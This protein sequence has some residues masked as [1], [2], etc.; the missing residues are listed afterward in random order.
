MKRATI[1]VLAVIG[2]A[3]PAI[4]QTYTYDVGFNIS[5]AVSATGTIATAC[6]SPIEP[7]GAL[8]GCSLDSWYFAIS[9]GGTLSS[10]AAGNAVSPSPGAIFEYTAQTVSTGAQGIFTGPGVFLDFN[11]DGSVTYHD[12]N[13]PG[14]ALQVSGPVGQIGTIAAVPVPMHDPAPLPVLG[15]FLLALWWWRWRIA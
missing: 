9:D 10:A 14:P 6:V 3:P 15:C 2:L 4:A 11:G 8:S 1:T 12:S 5:G 7:S 13:N